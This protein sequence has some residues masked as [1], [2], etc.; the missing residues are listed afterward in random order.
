[1]KNYLMDAIS[2]LTKLSE[3]YNV[4]RNEAKDKHD[5]V[6]ADLNLYKRQAVDES[7]NVIRGLLNETHDKN[8]G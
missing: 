5:N 8:N 3:N 2:E 1:M 7:I 6:T 4:L